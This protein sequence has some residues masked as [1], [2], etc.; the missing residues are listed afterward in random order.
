MRRVSAALASPCHQGSAIDRTMVVAVIVVRVV[1][2]ARHHVVEMIAVADGL[3]TAARTMPVFGFVLGAIVVRRAVG[4]IGLR[5]RHRAHMGL[6]LHLGLL[7]ELGLPSVLSSR[8]VTRVKQMCSVPWLTLSWDR[9]ANSQPTSE[10]PWAASA[11][12]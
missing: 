11:A 3:V 6:A 9:L 1:Q 4:G 2:M 5:D 10:E 8:V 12:T 7:S